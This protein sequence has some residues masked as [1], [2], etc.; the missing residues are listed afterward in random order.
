MLFLKQ[1]LMLPFLRH[2]SRTTRQID[3]NEVSNSKLKP[4][5][6]NCVKLEII[7]F[8]A[9]S[10]QPYKWGTI[11]LGHHV[12]GSS[13][14]FQQKF[15]SENNEI[16]LCVRTVVLFLDLCFDIRLLITTQTNPCMTELIGCS[17][18]FDIVD[19]DMSLQDKSALFP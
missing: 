19:N 11:I 18:N 17:C 7:E 9:P 5:L 13:L 6:C 10:Q 16:L 12:D 3:S 14:V 8:T 2:K 1:P 15:S 4:D